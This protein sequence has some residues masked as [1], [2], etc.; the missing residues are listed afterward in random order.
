MN[1]SHK[2]KW[3]KGEWKLFGMVLPF[4]IL[5]FLLAY[6]PLFG[7]IISLYDFRPGIP[8][9]ENEFIG[10]KYFKTILTDKNVLRSL[11]NTMIFSGIDLALKPLPMIFAVCLNEIT[12]TRFR[13]LVQTSTTLPHFISWI[14][15]YAFAFG[16]LSTDGV[17]NSVLL[18]LGI[19]EK[20]ILPLQNENIVYPFQIFLSKWKELGWGAI[21][22]IAAIAG[23]DQQE[24][25]AACLDGANRF[26]RA[27]YITIPN[28][29]PTFVTLLILGV[30]SIINT[31]YEQ[32]FIFKNS[33]VYDK[34]EVLDLYI[35]QMGLQLG[36]YSYATTVGILKSFVSIILLV[37]ANTVAKKVRG[38]SIM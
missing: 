26:Q 32:Y 2:T 29:M 6:V 23:I 5:L 35:Y 20:P 12:S 16:L 1:K 10:F 17:M 31:G 38:E 9:F 22:Y 28:L 15:V 25:E 11:G 36:D 21:V 14:I 18:D 4:M 37:A 33:F 3:K 8:L 34:I 24:Y 13:K 19:T 30:A 7:W 27:I